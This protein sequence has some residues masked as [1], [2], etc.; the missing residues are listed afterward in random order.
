VRDY[1]LGAGFLFAFAH[2]CI[3]HGLPRVLMAAWERIESI[4]EPR[5]PAA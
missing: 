1:D 2:G 5:L 3:L 4:Q